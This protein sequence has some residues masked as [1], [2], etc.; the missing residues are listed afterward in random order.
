MGQVG[1]TTV[2]FGGINQFH[3]CQFGSSR[4]WLPDTWS[5]TDPLLR[6]WSEWTAAQ[7]N[8]S[9][10][11][12]HPFWYP[13]ERQRSATI[14]LGGLGGS[15]P[16]LLVLGGQI[17]LGLATN[18]VF[19]WTPSPSSEAA[20]LTGASGGGGG[21]GVWS[22]L[23]FQTAGAVNAWPGRWDFGAVAVL[24]T[25]RNGTTARRLLLA[26]G[27]G[28][29]PQP[30]GDVWRSDDGGVTWHVC[31][32]P[33]WQ[34]RYGH[35]MATTSGGG[36]GGVGGGGGGGF[37][38]VYLLGGTRVDPVS[39]AVVRC[40]DMWRSADG[41]ESWV[42]LDV[43]GS[44]GP[45]TN[46]VALFLG[47]WLLVVK[48][49]SQ[50]EGGVEEVGAVLGAD[51]GSGGSGGGGTASEAGGASV[52]FEVLVPSKA[53]PWCARTMF[54]IVPLAAAPQGG[55][56]PRA[57]LLGGANS[58][59]LAAIALGQR[60]ER[61]GE[62][63][64]ASAVASVACSLA[65][66]W[67]LELVRA[68]PIAPTP[69]PTDPATSSVGMLV[70]VAASAALLF[71][72]ALWALP[73][74]Q[75]RRRE[76]GSLLHGSFGKGRGGRGGSGSSGGSAALKQRMLAHSI[77]SCDSLDRDSEEGGR[78]YG[79][80]GARGSPPLRVDAHG[81][82]L[83]GNVTVDASLLIDG[84]SV[85]L[86]ARIA[87]GSSGQVYEGTYWVASED[88]GGSSL[89]SSVAGGGGKA[90]KGRGKFGKG[91]L[92][93]KG[94]E[95]RA[96][97]VAVKELMSQSIS[98][99]QGFCNEMQMLS[100]LQQHP[101]VIALFGMVRPTDGG[102]GGG[103]ML[104]TEY[105][106]SSLRDVLTGLMRARQAS[107]EGGGMVG[108]AL[109][110][111]S[112]SASGPAASSMAEAAVLA[113]AR[114]RALL[115]GVA[116]GMEFIHS[117]SIIHRDL[118]PSNILVG[119]DGT[120]KICDFGIARH[121]TSKAAAATMTGQQGS[122]RYMAPEIIRSER[123]RY[124]NRVDV[125]SFG[126]TLYECCCGGQDPYGGLTAFEIMEGVTAHGLRPNIPQSWPP[127]LVALL[128]QVSLR[129]GG[130]GGGG[131]LCCRA[132]RLLSYCGCT[133]LTLLMNPAPFRCFRRCG[134]STLRRGRSLAGCA[135]TCRTKT[136]CSCQ[137][138]RRKWSSCR[139]WSNTCRTSACTADG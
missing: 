4:C 134:L 6:D 76:R 117:R 79:G 87:V 64:G 52:T 107:V 92:G 106:P 137:A 66:A 9:T 135:G 50:D 69:A 56:N 75:R 114:L 39:G 57:L 136:R 1:Q 71:G 109:P 62:R 53:V 40:G 85:E 30:F 96:L 17:P 24:R 133:A 77:D 93:G 124:S 88:E 91:K 58:S 41:G 2:V 65:D 100:E 11:G 42:Q 36:G 23:D 130:W 46:G 31:S 103:I 22:R 125:F 43:G 129:L 7:N 89:D 38:H 51:F 105:L 90:G 74:Y 72:F 8:K 83:I 118:K 97:K 108:S 33:G 16:S 116:S 138:T 10:G 131:L 29:K 126:I 25:L 18:S 110:S 78:L 99:A 47:S 120:T 13:G 80:S 34:P 121:V 48:S 37:Q 12:G 54:G 102:G 32:D 81:N 70:G 19:R 101:N 15:P 67:S 49:A 3:Q 27:R 21:G 84:A 61:G 60:G 104:V 45:T 127:S 82:V 139:A 20:A 111:S 94:R 26:G 119:A 59:C 63:G 123:S 115:V 5:A 112:S 122:P 55:G 132:A 35:A 98:D 73:R 28:T 14:A 113:P 44:L 95:K 68:S 86:G 128:Q